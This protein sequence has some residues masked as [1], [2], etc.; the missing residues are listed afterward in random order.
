MK[1]LFPSCQKLT[2]FY[3]ANTLGDGKQKFN[4]VGTDQNQ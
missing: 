4:K 2:K 3:Q 1:L